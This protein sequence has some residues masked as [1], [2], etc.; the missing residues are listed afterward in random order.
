MSQLV[1]TVP[2]PMIIEIDLDE[3]L[4]MTHWGIE[5]NCAIT[6]NAFLQLIGEN[7]RK[8][9]LEGIE[10]HGKDKPHQISINLEDLVPEDQR[11]EVMPMPEIM[12]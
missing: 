3:D 8:K 10:Q 7:L 1:C 9:C 6:V 4:R 11:Q 2:I 5:K 12:Q